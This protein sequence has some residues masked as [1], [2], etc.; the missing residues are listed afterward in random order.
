[1]NNSIAVFTSSGTYK[2]TISNKSLGLVKKIIKGNDGN[3]YVTNEDLNTVSKLNSQGTLIGSFSICNSPS[4]IAQSSNGNFFITSLADNK[5]YVYN[6]S[7][8]FLRTIG[9]GGGKGASQMYV[10]EDIVIDKYEN[11]FVADTENGRLSVFSQDGA[12]LYQTGR[13]FYEIISLES[14]GTTFL[15]VDCFH[16]IVRVLSEEVSDQPYSFYASLYPDTITIA[17]GDYDTLN[18]TICNNGTN[19][20]DFSISFVNMLPSGWTYSVSENSPY[21]FTIQPGST[22]I[23]KITVNIANS[24]KDGDKGSILVNITSSKSNVSKSL[25]ANIFVST[26]LPLTI[27][28]QDMSVSNGDSFSVPIFIKNATGIRGVAF[29]LNFDKN[30]ISYVGTELPLGATDDLAVANETATGITVATAAPSGES[31]EGK[32]QILNI[33]FKAKS[34]STNLINFANLNAYN[35]LDEVESIDFKQFTITS[36]PFLSVSFINGAVAQN[37]T[38]S[39]TGKTDLG[40][41]V[42]VNGNPVQVK[43]DGT[44]SVSLSLLY[45]TNLINIVS[46]AKSGEQTAISRTVYFKGSIKITIVMQI[47]N[48]I[49]TVNGMN[50]EIDPGRDTAPLILSGWNRTIVP[51]RAIVEVLGGS[52]S[53]DDSSRLVT[54]VFKDKTIKLWIDNDTAEVNGMKLK[55][56]TNN[57]SVK[58]II[59]NSRTMLPV[60]FVA[61]NLGCSVNWDDKTRKI[62]LTYPG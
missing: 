4:G 6:S 48:K 34:I 20:D 42:T 7:F 19:L 37:Q 45:N 38:F 27:Y 62:T 40:C 33:K 10:P 12:L 22:K 16:N 51:V 13:D 57:S 9:T 1:M 53:Y 47:G 14:E 17:P 41:S 15:A 25:I 35:I 8:K 2:S 58:P 39:F 31:L 61:E 52:I 46:K 18:L 49:M 55:I 26:N 30:A 24:A 43:S 36:G 44:F 23:V 21:I 56:D 32:L 29:D 11:L 28:S 50:Q 5:V 3:L 54:I 60:R 59:I